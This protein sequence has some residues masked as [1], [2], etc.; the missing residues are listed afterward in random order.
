MFA[1]VIIP[2]YLNITYTWSIPAEWQ[3]FVQP[4][5]RVE[6]ELRNKKYAGIIK[7]ITNQKP[8]AFNPKPILSILDEEPLLHPQQLAL[9]RW[10]AE[11]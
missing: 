10:M 5:L 7:A 11:Y 6:V 9:W 3:N 1:E 8:A 4:G 2:L